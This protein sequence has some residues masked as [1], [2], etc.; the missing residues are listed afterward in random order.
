MAR[1]QE[2]CQGRD[3]HC[4][5]GDQPADRG[6]AHEGLAPLAALPLHDAQLL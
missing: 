3:D 6:P 4:R 1:G 2:Q 5:H